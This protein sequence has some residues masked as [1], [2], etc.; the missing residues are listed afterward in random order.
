MCDL[1]G[2]AV[3]REVT[4][5]LMLPY[6]NSWCPFARLMF[7]QEDLLMG[8]SAE[9]AAAKGRPCKMVSSCCRI[10]LGAL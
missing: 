2:A 8:G 7:A 3:G 9:Y 6:R 1:M 4:H 10:I 5:R